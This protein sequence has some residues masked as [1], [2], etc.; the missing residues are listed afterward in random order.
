MHATLHPHRLFPM[1]LAAVVL[2]AGGC[3]QAPPAGARVGRPA[4]AFTLLDEN[5]RARRLEDFRGRVVF[6]NFWAT[7]C[8]PCRSELPSL[9]GLR[10]AMEGRPFTMLTVVVNDDPARA[11]RLLRLVGCAFPILEDPGGAAAAAYGITGVPET[12]IVG[13][14]G[15]L[16]EKAIGP[17]HW[18]APEVLARLEGYLPPGPGPRP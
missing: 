6:L 9:E 18:N 15:I 17:R 10:R 3:R 12:Y 14:D 11:R 4:P 7:W 1:L 13:P 2:A 16:R 8:P 5:G